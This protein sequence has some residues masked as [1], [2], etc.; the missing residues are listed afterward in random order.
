MAYSKLPRI[1]VHLFGYIF[2]AG[3]LP[4]FATLLLLPLLVHLGT[5]Q[6][7]RAHEKR[8]LE[9][10]FANK[11][12]PISIEK[13]SNSSNK[14][15][16]YRSLVAK[17]WFDNEHI[18]LLDNQLYQHKTGYHVLMP[19]HLQNESKMLLVNRGFV[20]VRDR[21]RLPNI[22]PISGLRTLTGLIYYPNKTLVLKKDTSSVHWP[23][24]VQS[25]DME[26][27]TGLLHQETYPFYLLLRTGENS[28]LVRDWHPVSFPAYRH[29]G[30]AIQ[31]FA[32]AL[33]LVVIYLSLNIS[34]AK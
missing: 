19:F 6:L 4:T 1:R 27:L 28:H 16:R 33:T 2:S 11:L 17:G 20:A 21:N 26:Q 24:R 9:R 5:W 12:N 14:N 29:T 34:R 10:E 30:Y 15:L 8:Q 7:H 18:I 3:F 13:V 25:I 31:W 32:L 22:P 23:L